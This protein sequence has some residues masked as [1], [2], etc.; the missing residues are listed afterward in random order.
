MTYNYTQGSAATAHINGVIPPDEYVDQVN[1]SVYTNFVA[2]QALKFAVLASE[3]LGVE[4]VQCAVYAQV[5]E[6]LVILFDETLGIHPEYEGY[7]GNTV[8]QGDVVLLHYPL[9]MDM[10]A[11]VQRADLEYYSERTDHNG[12]AMTW[13]MHAIGFLD[14]QDFSSAAKYFNMSFQDNLHAPLQVWTETVSQYSLSDSHDQSDSFILCSPMVMP[15]I[16][17]LAL[18]ASCRL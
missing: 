16:S 2:S 8:K 17:S 1:D 15:A 14:L 3:V 13:G 12:P 11:D 9:G 6:D 5:A 18:V 4:C 10:T 7:P